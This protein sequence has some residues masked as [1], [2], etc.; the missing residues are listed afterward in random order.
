MDRN[1]CGV[2]CP[3]S[4]ISKMHH[5]CYW[6]DTPGEIHKSYRRAK[7][8]GW[9][10]LINDHNLKKMYANKIRT[11]PF[12]W[13]CKSCKVLLENSHRSSYCSFLSISNKS[14]EIV[15]LTVVGDWPITLM[16]HYWSPYASNMRH[17]SFSPLILHRSLNKID[18]IEGTT[19]LPYP[20]NFSA[21]LWNKCDPKFPT[22][23]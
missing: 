20:P 19:V 3:F 1:S 8:I 6:N 4:H 2:R 15:K 14:G 11:K 21:S 22:L 10:F 5:I 23:Q 12:I 13:G 16:L 7:N 17:F 18:T 9:E